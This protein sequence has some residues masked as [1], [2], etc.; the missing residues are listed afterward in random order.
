MKKLSLLMLLSVFVFWGCSNDDDEEVRHIL[1][2]PDYEAETIDLGD[3]QHPVDTWSTSYDYAGQTYTTNYFH[4][5]LTDKSNIFEFDCTSSDI[6]GFGSDA[7]AFTNCTSGNYSAVTKKGVNNNTYVV[8]GASGYKVGSNS[9]TEVSIR[10][11]NSNNTNYSVKGLFITNS[12]YA[13]TSMTEGT[14]LYHNQGKED[15][16]D[17]TD[18]FK[19]TIYN[20]DKTMHV[21]CYLAEG[22]NILTEWKWINLSALGETKGLKFAL[23]STKEDEYGMMTPAYFCLDGITLIEK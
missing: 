18:S 9:D 6:Y 20:L 2:L 14:P 22:T 11:K 12:T 17:T 4:T 1:S 10:F 5:L 19:L 7:F 21:D 13:Y 3:T 8:V 23:T 16:F 15:K